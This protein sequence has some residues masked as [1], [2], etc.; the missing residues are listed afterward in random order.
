MTSLSQHPPVEHV[1]LHLSDTHLLGGGRQLYDRVDTLTPLK[2]LMRRVRDSEIPVEA[3]VFTGDLAD[4]A[5]PDAYLALRDAMEPWAQTLGAQLVWVMG[6]HDER[7]PFSEILWREPATMDTRDRVLRLGDLRLIVLDTSVPGFHHG[8]LTTTQLEWLKAELATP[9]PHGTLIAQHHPPIPTPIDLMGLIELHNQ[10][11]FAEVI[12]GTDVRGVL[13]GHLHYSTFSTLG[14]VPVSVSAASC[15][16][17]D[18]VA[19]SSKLL[20]AKETGRSASLIHV[21]PERVVFSQVP[22]DDEADITSYDVSYRAVIESMTPEARHHMFSDK[23]SDFNQ[24]AD[25]EQSGF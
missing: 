6:N 9:A 15:Y 13:A 8:E 21:Y 1:L 5:E 10:A 12:R 20:A 2:N 3:L 19:D 7:E 17:I 22:L 23:T 25:K 4:R 11:G 18:L 14:G 24:A 16:N